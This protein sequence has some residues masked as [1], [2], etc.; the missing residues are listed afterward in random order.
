MTGGEDMKYI[1]AKGDTFD[2]IAYSQYGNEELIKPIIDANPQ[3]AHI[4]V[5]DYGT[6]LIIPELDKTDETVFL[7]PWRTT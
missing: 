4:A 3:Y 7:P 1:T 2:I 6:E 5:F